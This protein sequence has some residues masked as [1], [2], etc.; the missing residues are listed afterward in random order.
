MIQLSNKDPY[1]NLCLN[2]NES[3][4]VGEEHRP[5][6]KAFSEKIEGSQKT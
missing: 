4:Y 5:F 1:S 6:I 3:F 2:G